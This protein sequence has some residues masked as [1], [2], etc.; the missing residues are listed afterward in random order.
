MD[1]LGSGVG[2]LCQN[3]PRQQPAAKKLTAKTGSYSGE[4]RFDPSSAETLPHPK[5]SPHIGL[6]GARVLDGISRHSQSAGV[7][8][9]C[10]GGRDRQCPRCRAWIGLG[11][12]SV[13]AGIYA[14]SCGTLICVISA[15]RGCARNSF[16]G[17]R[18]LRI[19]GEIVYRVVIAQHILKDP[20]KLFAGD[21]IVAG[22]PCG[23]RCEWAHAGK[24]IR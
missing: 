9:E 21:R 22:P 1:I 2:R 4:P 3:G 12:P 18:A 6:V 23:L 15:L 14:G 11:H 20:L 13:C 5:R 8:P 10:S 17:F 19:R 7:A 16:S 24:A